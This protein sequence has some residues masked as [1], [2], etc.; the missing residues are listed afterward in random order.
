[1]KRKDVSSDQVD[2]DLGQGF[3]YF[4]Q[5]APYKAHLERHKLEAEPKSNC[6]RHNAVNLANTKI[7]RGL[8][9]TG[10]ATVECMRH[11]MKRPCSVGDLQ[12]GER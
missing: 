7:D 2:P 1:L 5:E 11:D 10:V 6:S 9:A 3:A 8:A 12:V 4:V